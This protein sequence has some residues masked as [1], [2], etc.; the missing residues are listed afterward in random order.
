VGRDGS[1]VGR[2]VNVPT[3][4]RYLGRGTPNGDVAAVDEVLA[5]LLMLWEFKR[6]TAC[7][8]YQKN[9]STGKPPGSEGGCRRVL[10]PCTETG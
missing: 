6:R 8:S 7:R 5:D 3:H 2:I 10:G 1:P 4:A 9:S